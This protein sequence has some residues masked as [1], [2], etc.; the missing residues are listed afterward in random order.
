VASRLVPVGGQQQLARGLGVDFSKF[1][2]GGLA[3]MLIVSASRTSSR[4]RRSVTAC[5]RSAYCRITDHDLA[6]AGHAKIIEKTR[7]V[8][9]T[10]LA[11]LAERRI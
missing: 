7:D 11:Y 6:G 9:A 8:A 2:A 4:R 5:E 1:E 3:P 10:I